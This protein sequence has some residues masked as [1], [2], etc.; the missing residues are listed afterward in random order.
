VPLK[1]LIVEDESDIRAAL[2]AWLEDEEFEVAEASDGIEGLA[3]FER[4]HPDL[5][6]LDMNLPGL[7]G[8]ELCHRIRQVSKIPLIMFTAAADVEEVRKAIAVGATD[9]VLKHTGFDELLNRIS[10][11]LHVARHHISGDELEEGYSAQVLRTP[12]LHP[13]EVPPHYVVDGTGD[14]H[15]TEHPTKDDLWTWSGDYFG[16][17]EG[18]NLWTFDGRHVGRFRRHE[19]YRAN[20]AYMGD[21]VEGRLV[22]DWH[23]AGRRASSFTVSDNR[24]DHRFFADRAPFDMLVGCRDFPSGD[25]V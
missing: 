20:G 4:F 9:F 22:S 7:S 8:I 21:L 13:D 11:H 19:I 1:I 5:A 12:E 2:V 3:E 23:K 14:S 18:E 16:F 25:E 15:V 17:R 6:L 10:V 24:H